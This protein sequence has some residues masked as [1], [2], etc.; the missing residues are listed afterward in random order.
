MTFNPQTVIL[1]NVQ[2]GI[3]AV[4]KNSPTPETAYEAING[5]T[6]L[7]TS[8][9]L[10]ERIG[11]IRVN[12]RQAVLTPAGEQAVTANNIVDETGKITDEGSQLVNLVNQSRDKVN[13]GFGLLKSLI[14]P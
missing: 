1:N 14:N 10:L 6:A 4:I 11:L 5:S 7:I 13:E 9:N 3:L 2:K 8:R 12:A